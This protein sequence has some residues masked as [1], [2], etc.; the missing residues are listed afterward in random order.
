MS[1]VDPRPGI[2]LLL[3]FVVRVEAGK[4]PDQAAMLELAKRLRSI[5]DGTP[6]DVALD[7]KRPPGR[8]AAV[9][10]GNDLDRRSEL[11][12]RVMLRMDQ[13]K[14][15]PDQ[16]AKALAK[17]GQSRTTLLRAF[18]YCE[19]NPY[20]AA[21]LMFHVLKTGHLPKARKT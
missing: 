1:T 14:E 19:N 8:R 11:A 21:H 10:T 6:A 3:R 12:A 7:L 18:K 16:A 13:H 2:P 20:D 9:L 17:P 5:I 15:S 4:L